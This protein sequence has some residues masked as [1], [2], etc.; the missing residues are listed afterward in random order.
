MLLV[1]TETN[2]F[3]MNDHSFNTGVLPDSCA[4]K[5]SKAWS[6][7]HVIQH[8]HIYKWLWMALARNDF[9]KNTWMR[10]TN[11]RCY[12]YMCIHIYMHICMHLFHHKKGLVWQSGTPKSNGLSLGV[13]VLFHFWVASIFRH[14]HIIFLAD[15]LAVFYQKYL[16]IASHKDPYFFWCPFYCSRLHPCEVLGMGQ[17]RTRTGPI[18]IHHI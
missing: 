8:H 12:I 9:A 13:S 7:N 10:N 18:C 14:P 11:L 1:L 3:S 16:K 2:A 4:E 5:P 15:F 6:A 17:D